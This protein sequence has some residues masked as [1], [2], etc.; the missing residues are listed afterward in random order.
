MSCLPHLQWEYMSPMY[1][2][3]FLCLF[4]LGRI[5]HNLELKKSIL[6]FGVNEKSV[7]TLL[8]CSVFLLLLT[9]RGIL[10]ES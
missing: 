4:F 3:L 8:S 1:L 6:S 7:F 2:H 9:F 10:V 5:H